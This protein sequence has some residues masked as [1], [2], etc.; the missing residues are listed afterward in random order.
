VSP[1]LVAVVEPVIALT[2]LVAQVVVEQL[3]HPELLEQ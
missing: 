3:V 1:V 2:V